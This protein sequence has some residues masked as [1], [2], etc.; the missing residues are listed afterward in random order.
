LPVLGSA[1]FTTITAW[2]A[3]PGDFVASRLVAEHKLRR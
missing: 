3:L 2:K 1:A